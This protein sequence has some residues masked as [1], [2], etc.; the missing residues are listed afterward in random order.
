MLFVSGSG[1]SCGNSGHA[2][3]FPPVIVS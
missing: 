3:G 1:Q 2:T